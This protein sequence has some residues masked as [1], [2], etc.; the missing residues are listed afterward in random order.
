[1]TP[2]QIEKRKA[3]QRTE[4]YLAQRRIRDKIRKER[5]ALEKGEVYNYKPREINHSEALRKDKERRK[6]RKKKKFELNNE[7]INNYKKERCCVHCGYN[8]HPEILQFHH[9]G[10]KI[11]E[12][13]TRKDKSLDTLKKEIEKCI[14][15]CPNCHFLLHSKE[16]KEIHR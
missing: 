13:S 9:T 1:M 3:F 5:L 10:D 16:R 12:I 6:I 2:E 8:D 4:E 14:L 7:W 15:L 11:F